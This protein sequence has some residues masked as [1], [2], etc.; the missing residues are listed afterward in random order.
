MLPLQCFHFCFQIFYLV[1]SVAD[2]AISNFLLCI[3][4][5]CCVK[6]C[7][8]QTRTRAASYFT[9][10]DIKLVNGPFSSDEEED[11][12]IRKL[13]VCIIHKEPLEEWQQGWKGKIQ[14]R[15]KAFIQVLPNQLQS[16]FMALVWV[17]LYFM[18]QRTNLHIGSLKWQWEL[19][20]AHMANAWWGR[21]AE[22]V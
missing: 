11:W 19:N 18:L 22:K 21:G 7:F 2:V 5:I 20:E 3:W 4:P 10:Q 1:S 8:K 6:V 17:I 9:C 15:K 16:T 13:P 12:A 14:K